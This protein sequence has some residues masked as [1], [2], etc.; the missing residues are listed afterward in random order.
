MINAMVEDVLAETGR[1]LAEARPKSVADIRALGRPVVAFS[2]TMAATDRTV[3]A[4]C[5]S[6]CTSTGASTARTPRRAGW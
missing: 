2:E 6:A 5:T 4:S 1:R 3:K